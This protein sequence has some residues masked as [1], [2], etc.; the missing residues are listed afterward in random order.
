M[1]TL[2][3]ASLPVEK[4]TVRQTDKVFSIGVVRGGHGEC[5]VAWKILNARL[6]SSY[7]NLTGNA[8]F[9]GDSQL[10]KVEF[11]LPQTPQNVDEDSFLIQLLDPKGQ[12]NPM[13]GT[14]HAADV[15]VINDIKPAIISFTTGS[16][17]VSQ[18]EKRV[19][20]PVN[21]LH[22]TDGKAKIVWKIRS[23]YG[24]KSPYHEKTG[25]LEFENGQD[26]KNIEVNLSQSPV[27][28]LED[29]DLDIYLESIDLDSET[30][31]QFGKN[32]S[33][34]L[35]LKYDIKP[36]SFNFKQTE[37]DSRQTDGKV[38]LQIIRTGNVTG[39]ANLTFSQKCRSNPF[40]DQ[41]HQ[42]LMTEKIEKTK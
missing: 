12:N 33:C 15:T 22:H 4:I 37:L 25:T 30:L 36:A 35:A 27:P 42:V 29:D 6:G 8:K 16:L 39:A 2:P 32:R 41:I 26:L 34:K 5:I 18:S 10:F 24:G 19:L 23:K 20:L 31:S 17:S 3:T 13:L 28:L 40:Y 9:T 11:D 38:E 14:I 21:R 7:E 1:V